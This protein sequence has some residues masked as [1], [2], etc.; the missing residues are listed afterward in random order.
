MPYTCPHCGKVHRTQEEL[1]GRAD[2]TPE[3][4][5]SGVEA[6]PSIEEAEPVILPGVEESDEES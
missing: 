1:E 2:D 5:I 3:P 4:E 6:A